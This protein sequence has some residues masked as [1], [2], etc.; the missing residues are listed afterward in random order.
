M[1][2][3]LKDKTAEILARSRRREQ[4]CDLPLDLIASEEEA[5][6][7]QAIAADALGFERTGYALIGSSGSSRRALGL[8]QP[9]FSEIPASALIM[10]V[11]QFRLPPGAI[12]AQCE[13]V[14]RM[15]R[16]FPEAGEA[17]S[18][19]AVASAVLGC[20]PAIGILGRRTHQS[21][22]GN[23]AAI[24]DFGLHVATLCGPYADEFDVER[25]TDINVNVFLFGQT[26]FAGPATSILRHPLEALVWLANKLSAHGKR[27]EPNHLIATGSCTTILRVLPGQ[28]LAA[29]FGPFGQVDCI[30]S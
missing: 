15:L 3:E 21:F 10:G 18:R 8:T 1:Y 30:F 6:G 22:A 23:N 27:L 20:H 4:L 29:D 17:I 11:K 16:P 19:E 14:F 5:Y 26:M 24:V 12:G 7:I 28:H 9:V 2:F 25:M 13:F